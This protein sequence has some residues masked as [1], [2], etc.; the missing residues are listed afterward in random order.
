VSD[1]R[2]AANLP[3]AGGTMTGDTLHGDNVKAKFGTGN[4]LEIFH[5]GSKSQI[6]D[7]GTGNLILTASNLTVKDAG[8]TNKYLTTD[9]STTATTI[10]HNN[11]ARLATTATGVAV[12]GDLTADNITV[13][14]AH[15]LKTAHSGTV[16]NELFSSASGNFLKGFG[17]S[18]QISS[19][20]GAVVLTTV[21]SQPMMFQTNNTERMRIDSS[22]NVLIGDSTAD[23]SS[24][25][26]VSGNGSSDVASFMYNGNTGTFLQIDCAAPNGVVELKAD[27]RSG[28]YPPLTFKT[29]NAERMRIENN[30]FLLN[31]GM[32]TVIFSFNIGLSSTTNFDFTIP[33]DVNYF[34]IKAIIGYYPGIDYTASIHG[35][36][37]YRSDAGIVRVQNFNDSSSANSGSWAVSSPN[38][39]TIRV[40]KNGGNSTSGARGFI[41]V[42]YREA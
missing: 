18:M 7:V 14:A 25:L 30:G 17:D 4:D 40:R 19:E 1:T 24:K 9:A 12:T 29:G 34:E 38:N 35:L 21:A 2:S 26:V 32:K 5:D 27:A 20:A 8:G 28:N 36:Y 15:K 22:G 3:K 41:E 33:N 10:Y 16:Y 39:T 13:A 23:R 31:N 6:S 11:V 37:A 42:K